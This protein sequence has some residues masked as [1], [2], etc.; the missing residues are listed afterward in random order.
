MNE[1]NTSAAS[2]L[3]SSIEKNFHDLEIVKV[4]EVDHH[5]LKLKQDLKNYYN[6]A[7]FREDSK[8]LKEL[9][10]RILGRKT[11]SDWVNQD[12]ETEQQVRTQT[13]TPLVPNLVTASSLTGHVPPVPP[14]PPPASRQVSR[15]A[16]GY[17]MTSSAPLV[18]LPEVQRQSYAQVAS[19]SEAKRTTAAPTTQQKYKTVL[20]TDS[21]LR[22]IKTTDIQIY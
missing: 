9:H 13:E 10:Q 15:R 20:I 22:H 19:S 12:R 18:P 8:L 1:K 17:T 4:D 21:I 11:S 6:S 16:P 3:K 5:V 7:F 2:A 14:V